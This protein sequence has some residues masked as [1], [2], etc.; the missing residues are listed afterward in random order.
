[1]TALTLPPEGEGPVLVDGLP[2]QVV[3]V[4][5]EL[6]LALGHDH[7]LGHRDEPFGLAVV[8]G[9]HHRHHP[10]DLRHLRHVEYQGRLVAAGVEPEHADAGHG[11]GVP[12]GGHREVAP[13]D[14]DP[15]PIWWSPGGLTPV[16]TSRSLSSG[17]ATARCRR[18][19]A[20]STTYGW[21]A[22]A[23]TASS[24]A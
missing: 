21:P 16:M 12:Y 1:M 3:E 23:A 6:D 4:L 14:G 5:V 2:G 10:R 7:P 20:A 8:V 19:S 17:G 9:D 11:H 15:A 22:P 13:M 18:W 24:T